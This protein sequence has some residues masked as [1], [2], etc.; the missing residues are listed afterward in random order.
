MSQKY[1]WTQKNVSFRYIF[2]VAFVVFFGF[3]LCRSY[4]DAYKKSIEELSVLDKEQ[5]A[6]VNKRTKMG[7]WYW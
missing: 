4:E 3:L 6:K 1:D 2:V 5:T 7:F